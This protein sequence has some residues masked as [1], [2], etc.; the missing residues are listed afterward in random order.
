MDTLAQIYH[1][2]THPVNVLFTAGLAAVVLYWLLVIFGCF[3]GDEGHADV[4]SDL[5]AEAGDAD[6]H[7]EGDTGHANVGENDGAHGSTQFLLRFLHV[8]DAPLMPLLSLLALCLWAGALLANHQF[9]PGHAWMTAL[10]LLIPNLVVAAIVT[11]FLAY[12]VTTVFRAMNHDAAA[13]PPIAGSLCRIL[14]STANGQF[15]E[16]V[17]ERPGAPL[18]IHVRTAGEVLRQ[19]ERAFVIRETEEPGTYQ[20]TSFDPQAIAAIQNQVK[21]L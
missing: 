1:E 16:A 3:G 6:L 19:G 20:I 12:P 2:A 8:G 5:S 15:G 17:I 14:T 13:P 9:N 7:A 10:L 4:H 18:Q 11:H 21:D